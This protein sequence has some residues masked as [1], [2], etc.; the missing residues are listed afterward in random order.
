VK[1]WTSGVVKVDAN[2]IKW[3]SNN[4]T[5][6]FQKN[7]PIQKVNAHQQ[8]ISKCLAY[9]IDNEDVEAVDC[10]SKLRYICEVLFK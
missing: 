8:N 2:C 3:C 9:G 6:L 10:N 1:V 5:S 7:K 4:K